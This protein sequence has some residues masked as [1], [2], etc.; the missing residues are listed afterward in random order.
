MIR[1]HESVSK[2]GFDKI[3]SKIL[4]STYGSDSKNKSSKK[5]SN[6]KTNDYNAKITKL[7]AKKKY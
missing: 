4:K 7:E 5:G 2:G 1:N 3:T 6:K